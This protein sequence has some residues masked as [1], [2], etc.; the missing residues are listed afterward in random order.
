M[1]IEDHI[2]LQEAKIAALNGRR[3]TAQQLGDVLL[4]ADLERE[5]VSAEETLAR[6]KAA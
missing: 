3:A 4:L 1:G 2:Q 6:L 5:L